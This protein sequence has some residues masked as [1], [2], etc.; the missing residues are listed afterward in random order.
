MGKIMMIGA[1]KGGVGKSVTAYNLAYCLNCHNNSIL[2]LN[3]IAL[4]QAP[5][6]L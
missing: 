4:G 5:D 3:T 2:Y 6:E 1:M